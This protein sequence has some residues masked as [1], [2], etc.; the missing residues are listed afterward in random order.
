MFI[1]TWKP[2]ACVSPISPDVR[3][4]THAS[5]YRTGDGTVSGET[6][7]FCLH[8]S[9]PYCLAHRLL[10]PRV[11]WRFAAAGRFEPGI[12]D[13]ASPISSLPDARAGGR[14]LSWRQVAMNDLKFAFRQLRRNP[15]FT[16]IAVLSLA[17]GIGANVAIFSLINVVSGLP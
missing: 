6:G 17:L 12:R 10:V 1:G 9:G 2:I 11:Q 16:T 15:G 14:R 3:F 8:F 4:G 5:Q 13:E 7:S